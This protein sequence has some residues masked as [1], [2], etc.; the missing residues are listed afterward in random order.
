MKKTILIIEDDFDIN[1]MIKTRL[2]EDGYNTISSYD[3]ND[4]LK[5]LNTFN[6]DLII[7]DIILPKVNGFELCKTI[8]K[9]E[10]WCHIP[11]ILMTA[12]SG[13]DNVARNEDK[14][15]ADACIAKPFEYPELL[16]T[17]KKLI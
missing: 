10:S 1:E 8:K 11:I 6:P 14:V 12:T 15:Q 4:A 9:N 16:E 3:G 7:L 17:I 2:E 13:L 5:K